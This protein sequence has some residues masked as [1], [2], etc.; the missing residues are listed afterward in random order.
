MTDHE[1]DNDLIS[2]VERLKDERA[3]PGAAF[4]GDLRRNLVAR[5]PG[6]RPR[7][8]RLNA[9]IAA[10]AGSGS[11]LFAFAAAGLAGIG[12]FGA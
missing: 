5:L 8:A 7:P 4:R 11:A 2:M 3:V 10:W 9:T 12:P 6:H 1:W